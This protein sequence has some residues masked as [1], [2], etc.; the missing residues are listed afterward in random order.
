MLFYSLTT[1]TLVQQLQRKC[2]AVKQAWLADDSAGAGRLH[3]LRCWW[4]LLCKTGK[5]YGYNTNCDKTF[6]LVKPGLVD[7][8]S[9]I[10]KGTSVQ[11]RVRGHSILAVPLEKQIL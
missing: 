5:M 8:A 4:D 7:E 10:F 2:V 6:L 1:L 3:D 11:I 9:D